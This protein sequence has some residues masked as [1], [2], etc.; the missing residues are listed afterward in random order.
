MGIDCWIRMTRALFLRKRLS[1]TFLPPIIN[2]AASFF[3][4]DGSI[5][6]K[7]KRPRKGERET[8]VTREIGDS[9]YRLSVCDCVHPVCYAIVA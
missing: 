3:T 2:A 6:G 7:S 8:G 4:Q 9:E 5:L 1:F